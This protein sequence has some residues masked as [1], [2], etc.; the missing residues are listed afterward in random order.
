MKSRREVKTMIRVAKRYHEIR[1]VEL[2]KTNLGKFFSYVNNRV[3]IKS[4][5]GS[6]KYQQGVL[7]I[8]DRRLATI[9][10]EYF[11][12]VFIKED[13]SVILALDLREMKKIY[14]NSSLHAWRCWVRAQQT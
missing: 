3:S 13:I 12:S 8:E 2:T 1:I 11:A 14:K 4:K 6:L 7:H 5:L 10:N 9:F